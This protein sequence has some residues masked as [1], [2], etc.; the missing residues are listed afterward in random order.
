LDAAD[1]DAVIVMDSDLQHPPELIPELIQKWLEGHAVVLAVRQQTEGASLFKRLSSDGFYSVFNLLSDVKLTSGAADFC[2]L[3]RTAHQALCQMPERRRFLRGMI[4]WM[5]FKT[6][7]VSYT[8]PPRFAGESKYGVGRMLA[9]ALDATF[10]FSTRPIRLASKAGVFCI[11]AGVAYLCYLLG[12]YF[13]V[14]DLVPG[15]ASIVGT[16]IVMGG[17]QLLSIGLIGEYLAHIFEEVKARPRYLF[18][19]TPDQLDFGSGDECCGDEWCGASQRGGI[20]RGELAA[21]AQMDQSL[22][23]VSLP[24]I[25]AA[26]SEPTVIHFRM[27]GDARCE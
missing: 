13:V 12:R 21:R 25:P 9:L 5:G 17:F 24:T 19:Q 8:A 16:I 20:D 14:G 2:L 7:R 26:A 11:L 10:S 23:G 15:W 1:G 3:S 18:K 27:G 22:A 6:A 4:A